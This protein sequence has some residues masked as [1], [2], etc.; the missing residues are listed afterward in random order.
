MSRE[1]NYLCYAHPK[2][3]PLRGGMEEAHGFL[4]INF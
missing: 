4:G 3:I 2:D 1:D